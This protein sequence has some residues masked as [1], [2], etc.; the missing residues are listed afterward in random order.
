MEAA[1]SA[2]ASCSRELALYEREQQVLQWGASNLAVARYSS[3]NPVYQRKQ[4]TRSYTLRTCSRCAL[5]PAGSEPPSSG[6]Q[7]RG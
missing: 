5:L 7:M 3:L 6:Q 1:F 2:R 4:A